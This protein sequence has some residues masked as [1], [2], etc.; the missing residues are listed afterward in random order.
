M[1]ITAPI[2]ITVSRRFR[3]TPERAFDAWL[4]PALARQFLFAT[5]TGEMVRVEIDA[6]VGGTFC[7][8]ERRGDQEAAHYGTYVAIDR[9]RHLV[10]TFAVEPNAAEA[11]TVEIVITPREA[12]CELTLTHEMKPE[13][14]AY[15]ERTEA[16]WRGTV[17]GLAATI[18]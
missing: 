3:A 17:D 2:V 1:S 16:G 18:E 10:F 15:T 14:A 7:I 12:G 5:P 4:D 8:V 6:R 9:P 13:W 11:D